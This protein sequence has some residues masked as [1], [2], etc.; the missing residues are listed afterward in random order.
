MEEILIA[1]A[2]K[3]FQCTPVWKF[4]MLVTHAVTVE[5]VI[6][7]CCMEHGVKLLE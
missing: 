4:N 3:D 7:M 5:D 6:D 2:K 1:V